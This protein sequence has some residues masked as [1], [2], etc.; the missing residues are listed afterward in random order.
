MTWRRFFHRDRADAEQRE[1]LD[2]YLDRTSEEYVERG[3][4]PAAAREAAQRKLGNPMLIREDIYRMNTLTW[5]EVCSATSAML[6][7]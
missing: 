6:C 3:M 1:E 2:F 7:G 5:M 4:E